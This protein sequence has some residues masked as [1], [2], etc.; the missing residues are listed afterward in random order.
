MKKIIR[1]ISYSPNYLLTNL[2]GIKAFQYQHNP[3]INEN[4]IKKVEQTIYGVKGLKGYEKVKNRLSERQRL[5][6]RSLSQFLCQKALIRTPLIRLT[7][8][9]IFFITLIPLFL[10]LLI[11]SL[12]D[13][14][15]TP[16]KNTDI[17]ILGHPNDR[18]LV[19]SLFSE[20]KTIYF[21][22]NLVHFGKRE[23]IFIIHIITD[24]PRIFLYPGLLSNFLRW[25]SYYGYIVQHF[26]PQIIVNFFE[27]VSSSSLITAYLHEKGIKHIN[28]MHGEQ[29]PFA[30]HAFC[31]FDQFNVWGEYFKRL[32]IQQRCP[33]DSFMITGNPYHKFLFNEIRY[34]KQPRPKCL[35]IIHN[36]HLSPNSS[37]YFSLLKILKLLDSNW[38]IHFRPHPLSKKSALYCF[39]ALQA[40]KILS[41]KGIQIEIEWPDKNPLENSLSNSRIVVGAQSCAILD[42]WVAGCKIIYLPGLINKNVLMERYGNSVNVLYA[43]HNSNLKKF[44]STPV[45]FNAHENDL[46]NFITSVY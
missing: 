37:Y 4:I 33:V 24:C 45:T 1:K 32:F 23:L 14:K 10:Y 35:L 12:I 9:F 43:N 11:K 46:V 36:P 17:I 13:T 19:I 28:Q 8:S 31:E 6:K 34:S 29:F 18:K 25:L 7:R 21:T 20:K 27:G 38:K 2:F 22:K 16:K 40:N 3:K 15:S 44:L 30:G 41:K 5:C 39:S 42:A 26:N